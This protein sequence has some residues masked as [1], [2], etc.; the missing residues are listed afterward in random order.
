MGG[1]EVEGQRDLPAKVQRQALLLTE[2]NRKIARYKKLIK[3]MMRQGM[4]TD[5]TMIA[6]ATE[7]KEI[8][9]PICL[10]SPTDSPSVN[11]SPSASFLLSLRAEAVRAPSPECEKVT[12]SIDEE[13]SR[14][15]ND[16]RQQKEQNSNG[17]HEEPKQEQRVR[18][19]GEADKVGEKD[20]EVTDR[21][22]DRT[23]YGDGFDEEGEVECENI[24]D[25]ERASETSEDDS[26]FYYHLSALPKDCTDNHKNESELTDAKD[27]DRSIS[28][29]TDLH[30]SEK[31]QKQHGASNGAEDS[32]E[33]DEV[34]ALALLCQSTAVRSEHG[35]K[36]VLLLGGPEAA[37]EMEGDEGDNQGVEECVSK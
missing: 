31:P 30:L 15:K 28:M 13:E 29:L 19:H 16:G 37:V 3:D 2:A 11:T 17:M 12:W 4:A 27:A 5:S 10:A 8:T 26:S 36:E 20:E 32:I 33:E 25:F 14:P 21:R 34:Q 9:P 7:M 6:T 35:N 22:C 18:E 24:M 1:K 23:R